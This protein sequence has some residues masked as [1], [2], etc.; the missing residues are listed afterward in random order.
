MILSK[1]FLGD[2]GT[3]FDGVSLKY[4]S[5]LIIFLLGI[6]H[7]PV[8][9][10]D[11]YSPVFN[12]EEALQYIYDQCDFGP[13]PPGSEN[14]SDCRSYIVDKLE[15]NGWEVILQNFTYQETLC[16]N[17]LAR[18]GPEVNSTMILGAHYDTRPKADNDPNPANHNLPVLG[19]N[20]GASGVAVLLELA[21]V[22]PEA[23]RSYVELVFFDAEDSG[24]IDGWDWIQGSRYFVSQLSAD[25]IDSI[26]AMVLLDMVGDANLRIPKEQNSMQFPS[27]QNTI[28]SIAHEF[29]Y[30]SIF[31][32]E[33]GGR[34]T[35]D[36]I[37]FL[38]ADI[39]AVDLIH[40][41]FP[42]TWHTI[43]DTPDKCSAASLQAVGRVVEVFVVDYLPDVSDFPQETPL[44]FLVILIAIPLVIV[45]YFIIR[46][47]Q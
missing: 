25:R 4:S 31:L 17:I 23:V 29:G 39:P 21:K 47:Q 28:W 2:V 1:R 15:L 20:D 16:S 37:P 42:S 44:D 35:D 3:E 5:L 38:D 13:R 30:D 12:G 33:T 36:H 18:W 9:I 34:I 14:L 11:D 7:I 45:S 27:L 43:E 8:V 32:N 6:P 10:G 19:A 22:L 46:R 40:Y 41:P 24:N 26:A